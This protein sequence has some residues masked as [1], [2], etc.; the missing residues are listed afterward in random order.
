M[1][2]D[3]SF[4][5]R[6]IANK[7]FHTV[8]TARLVPKLAN[9]PSNQ[10]TSSP[11]DPMRRFENR[12][13]ETWNEENPGNLRIRSRA[14]IIHIHSHPRKPLWLLEVQIWASLPSR[15]GWKE[16]RLLNVIFHKHM[17]T[18]YNTVPDV[19]VDF[20]WRPFQTIRACWATRSASASAWAD[21]AG[22]G[23]GPPGK[24]LGLCNKIESSYIIVA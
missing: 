9:N 5:V 11:H 10:T 20:A 17:S 2:Y 7:V 13:E 18:L 16:L 8:A 21:T 12:V 22:W 1:I 19:E 14:N 15:W 6:E 3:A 23:A 4:C 24:S